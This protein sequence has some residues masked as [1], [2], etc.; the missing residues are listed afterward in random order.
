MRSLGTMLTTALVLCYAFG[1]LAC[2]KPLTPTQ[3]PP[4]PGTHVGWYVATTGTSG[5]SGATGSPWDLQTALS[6]GNGKVQP[7]D[8]IWL[9]VG[10]YSGTFLSTLTGTAAN[11]IVVRAYPG[12]RAMIDGGTSNIETL[13]VNGGYTVYWGFEVMQSSTARLGT[14]GTGSALRPTGVYI[15]PGG[16]DLAF[17]NLI[18]HDTGHGFYTENAAH[19]IVIYGC[20]I[21]NG[22]EENSATGG[23]SDGHGIYIKNDG[24]GW[25]IARDN[26]VFNQFGFGIHGYAQAGQALIQLVF[27]GNVLFNNGTPSDYQNPNLQLGGTVIADSDSVTNNMLYFSS[28]ASPS[29]GYWNARLGYNT[30]ANGTAFV[31]NNYLVGGSLTLDVGYWAN[32]VVQGNTLNGASTVVWQHD[33]AAPGT[34]H[35][36]GNQHYRDPTALAWEYRATTYNFANWEAAVGVTDQAQATTPTVTQV[37]VR[38]N[39]Y[40]AGRAHIVIFNWGSLTSVAVPVT[41]VLNSGDAYEVRNV[42]DVFGTA[43]AS[44]TYGGGGTI[45][46]PLGGVNPPQPIGGSFQPLNKTGPFFD[47]FLLKHP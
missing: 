39:R 36:S 12:E 11:P 2:E 21:Y 1:A 30:L 19:N 37:F 28:S 41:G 38:P 3:P 43:V 16:H 29:A 46:I 13:T 47:A 20:I 44:G 45:T 4:P 7:G 8:T 5:G 32:L 42:Q 35:W 17:V 40:E 31:H 6:G 22:G 18:I 9:R 10:T 33:S 14:S 25:K 27:D 26:V 23:R 15:Q 24:T 34:Q